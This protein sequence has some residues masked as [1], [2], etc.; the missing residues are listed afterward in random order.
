MQVAIQGTRGSRNAEIDRQHLKD[1]RHDT[2][3]LTADP[4]KE[5]L[6]D[7]SDLLGHDRHDVQPPFRVHAGDPPAE[8]PGWS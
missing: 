1:P 8:F 4:V 7:S 5:Q 3:V 6:P 2:A